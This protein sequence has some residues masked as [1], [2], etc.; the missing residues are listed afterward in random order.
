MVDVFI[1]YSTHD[2]PLARFMH[3]HLTDEGISVFL[4][5]I[6]VVPGPSWA[7]EILNALNSAT[8]VL[9]LASRSACNSAYV[10]QEVGAAIVSKKQLIPVVWDLPPSEL[11]GWAKQYQALNLA[12]KS[13]SQ[14]Q[15]DITAIAA[16]IRAKNATGLVIA[17]LLLA[18][19]VAFGS[20]G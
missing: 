14:V 6:S 17:G 20:K 3:K 2:E 15:A 18:G 10:Q 12:G 1:S 11:P 19:L 9:F 7:P 13:A 8:W 5:S 16:R 4:A